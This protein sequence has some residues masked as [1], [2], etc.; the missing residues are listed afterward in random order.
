MAKKFTI[1]RKNSKLFQLTDKIEYAEDFVAHKLDQHGSDIIVEIELNNIHIEEQVRK[2]F[3]NKSIESLAASIKKDGLL[4]PILIMEHPTINKEY[5]LLFGENRYR[6]FKY[7]KKKTIPSRVTPYIKNTGERKIVQ[8]TENLHRK[9]LNPFELADSF[10]NIKKD[11]NITLEELANRVARSIS[12]VK[13]L[14]RIHNL[15]EAQKLRLKNTGFKELRNILNRKTKKSTPGVLFDQNEQLSLFKETKTML[16]LS[17]ISL[18]F[19]KDN[20]EDLEKK[21]LDCEKFL[22]I[23][24]KKLKK[25]SN[26]EENQIN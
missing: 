3:D 16:K 5:V 8:L 10:M 20:K 11:L 9:N 13:D 15:S 12:Y 4:Y 21:I 14:S 23:A 25:F 18:N 24:K 19:K 7:L 1:E 17:P 22:K 26:P 6:A 2:E